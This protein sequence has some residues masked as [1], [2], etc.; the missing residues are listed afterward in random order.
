MSPGPFPRS[1]PGPGYEAMFAHA[2]NYLCQGDM[3]CFLSTSTLLSL[4]SMTS[5]ITSVTNGIILKC[6]DL[7]YP[8]SS[9]IKTSCLCKWPK[10]RL[11]GYQ[12]LLSQV[13][14]PGKEARWYTVINVYQFTFPMVVVS[15][16]NPRL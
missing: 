16:V 5:S 7:P 6:I 13:V 2:R 1:A 8:V 14:G 3:Q 12:T 10:W 11:S 15:L 4:Q 9:H